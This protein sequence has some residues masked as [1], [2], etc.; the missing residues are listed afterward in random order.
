MK[1]SLVS[2]V[3][4]L[5]VNW[6][7]KEATGT[8]IESLLKSKTKHRFDIIV[9]DNASHDG[10]VDYIKRR[11]PQVTVLTQRSNIGFTGGVNV[12]LS[13]AYQRSFSHVWLLNNDTRVDPH[14]LHALI[15]ASEEDPSLVLGAKI[16]FER[17]HEYHL[18]RYKPSDQG[19][20]LW[21][22]GGQIDWKNM[23]CH[24]RGVDE[25]DVG[26]YD[27]PSKT[28]FI[29]GCSIFFPIMLLDAVGYLDNRYF[30]YYEDVDFSLRAIRAGYTLWYYPRAKLWHKNAGSS[31]RPGN[32]IQAYYLTR[33]RLLLGMQYG[34]LR[35]KFALSREAIRK[36]FLGNT[37]EKRAI[38]DAALM[39]FGK[40]H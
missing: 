7:S 40:G 37:T 23:Y 13:Y 17:G 18:Q 38:R 32:S 19:K 6:N 26:Q 20:V 36:L 4:I 2:Y 3:A 27:I 25:I 39:R 31:G 29:T 35:T 14:A 30:A 24:H 33:N 34:S 16:Y 8:C 9:V 1:Q 22:A 10:S 28:G 12:G 5:L 15:T 11:Y 21:Y